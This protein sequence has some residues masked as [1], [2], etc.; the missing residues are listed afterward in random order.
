MGKTD[1]VTQ[2]VRRRRQRPVGKVI[3]DPERRPAKAVGELRGEDPQ[4]RLALAVGLVEIQELLDRDGALDAG[5]ALAVGLQP[6]GGV[7]RRPVGLEVELQGEQRQ[8]GRHDRA[9]RA[10]A[11]SLPWR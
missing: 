4:H 10:G 3:E 7:E 8:P 2:L 6:L 1:R 9:H 11:C 5:D